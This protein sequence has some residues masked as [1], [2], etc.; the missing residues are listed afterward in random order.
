MRAAGLPDSTERTIVGF[1]GCFAA[2][3]ALKLADQIV[4][5]DAGVARAGGQPGTLQPASAGGLPGRPQDAQLPAVRRR[6]RR[7]PGHGGP[8]RHRPRPLP[9]RG[10]PAQP[11]TDHLAH[12]RQ[13]L[14]D[15]P[16]RP[17]AR[18]HPPLAAGARARAAARSDRACR[19]GRSTPAA[20][21]SWTRS[22]RRFTWTPTRCA[23]SRGVLRD[24]GN[25]SSATLMF[26]LDRILGDQDARG[27]GMAM[28]FGPG[29]S[30]ETFAFRRAMNLSQRSTQAE[31]M[32][33]DCVD[34]E[35]YSALPARPVAGQRRHPD[36]SPDA[37]LAGAHTPDGRL[38]RAGRRLRPRRRASK[39]P[40][41]LPGRPADRDRPQPLG[42]AAPR[43]R[44]PILPP[45]S[46]SSTATR[47]PIGPTRRSDFIITL[48]VHPPPDQTSRSSLP[49]LAAGQR[50]KRLVHRRPAPPLRSPITASRCSPASLSGTASFARTARSRSPAPSP[51][52]SGTRCCARPAS[53]TDQA[54]VT[55]YLPF[56]L[57]VG[58][59]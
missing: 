33:T 38:F 30:V 41:P 42:D 50:R 44:R 17:G 35:D 8:G 32:D 10:H 39:H 31:R 7:R 2:V 55:W 53:P 36:A 14:R 22:S 58:T 1:M 23:I 48:A 5:A 3:N 24:Y 54:F 47:S 15:A 6:R 16:V 46:T 26:V 40:P 49:A 25:M 4:R 45:K 56:R 9:G 27:A 37:G 29:L 11:G 21:R 52:P 13:R 20:V 59:R 18:P 51:A 34:F 43:P 57:C 28:A 19:S 12:R